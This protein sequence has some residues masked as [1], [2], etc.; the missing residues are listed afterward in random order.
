[1]KTARKLWETGKRQSQGSGSSAVKEAKP[2]KL[3][4]NSKSKIAKPD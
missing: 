4:P 3:D 2:G 1:M